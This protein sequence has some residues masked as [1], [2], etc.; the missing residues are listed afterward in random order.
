LRLFGA[1]R[2][3]AIGKPWV[4][5]P[6]MGFDKVEKVWKLSSSNRG[7]TVVRPSHSESLLLA[8]VPGVFP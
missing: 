5:N 1:D 8:F 7:C 4:K 6:E 2:D 3:P